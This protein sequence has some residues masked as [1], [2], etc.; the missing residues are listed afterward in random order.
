MRIFSRVTNVAPGEGGLVA[1]LATLMLATAAGAA[2]GATA[3]EALLFANFDLA[4]LPLLY[5]AL[6]AT[7]FVCTLVASGLLAGGDRARLYVALPGVLAAA[8][9]IERIAA[10]T[11]QPWV[12]AALWLGMNVVTTLQ[13][14]G[15]WGLA[16][17]VCDVRQA[18]RVFPL[19]NAA[20][21]GGAVA[22]SLLVTGLVRFLDVRD[23]LLVWALALAL[24]AAIAFALQARVP[25]TAVMKGEGLVAEMRRGFSIVQASRLLR[26]LAI[27]LV[28]F[29]LLYFSLA[30]PFSRGARAAYPDEAALATFLALFNGATT[31][32]ALLASLFVA[33]RLYARIGVVNA[34]VAFGGVYLAGF[35]AIASSAAFAVLVAARFAQT[36]WLTGIA[37]TAYQALFNPVPPERRDQ[38]RAFMEGVPGQAGIALAG[39]VLLAGDA[40]DP[41]ALA[42]VGIVASALTVAILWRIRPAYGVALADA[43]RAGRPQPF[44]PQDDPFGALRTDADALAVTLRGLRSTDV[45]ERRVSAEVLRDLA[46]PATTPKLILALDDPDDGVRGTV[47][48]ALAAVGARDTLERFAEDED[49]TVRAQVVLALGGDRLDALARHPNSEMRLALVAALASRPES[50]PGLLRQLVV[51]ADDR[52]RR[53][54]AAALGRAPGA[55]V[56]DLAPLVDDPD[57]TVAAAALEGLAEMRTESAHEWL[58][59]VARASAGDASSDA[60][61]VGRL[62]DPVNDAHAL[63]RDALRDRASRPAR[64]AVRAALAMV[65]RGGADLVLESL[66][67]ADRE[68]RASAVELLEAQGGEILRPLVPLWEPSARDGQTA[69]SV[70][71]ELVLTDPDELVRDAAR[72]AIYGGGA[73][74]TL[75]TISMMERVLFLRKVSLFSSLSPQDL[76]QIASLAHEELHEDG[77]AIARHGEIGDR[78]FVIASGSVVVKRADGVV[79]AKRGVGDAV[80]EMSLVADMPRIASLI[81]E[82]PVRVLAI[83]RR[84]FESILRD[85]PQVAFAIIRVLA[86]RLAESAA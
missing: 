73:M 2:M 1:A 15:A 75:S 68:R 38:I 32:V 53:A 82:G 63:V 74:E 56:E 71:H 22:G 48:G 76:K 60:G 77:A 30:L 84:E 25:K 10:S 65:G 43:L 69:V 64:R 85:R 3:T 26:L 6:G 12:Y 14:I 44:L 16:G 46:L 45:A 79:L 35:V 40:M 78:M 33:N 59:G 13:G 42:I 20:K 28:F 8:V 52:V 24:A 31:V 72:R 7:T 17:A 80:G 54:A 70:L 62:G 81:A 66:E 4:K 34:I 86:A 55:Q 57:P 58:L 39:V 51:D 19:L 37:D 21:I 36:V 41:R 47:I 9:A 50:S 23:L 67:S 29:S 18:K 49:P 83:G 27:S 61:R 11:G 5:V